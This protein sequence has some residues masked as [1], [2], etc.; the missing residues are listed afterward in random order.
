MFTGRTDEVCCVS[1]LLVAQLKGVVVEGSGWEGVRASKINAVVQLEG[2]TMRNNSD[3]DC[4]AVD[5][6]RIERR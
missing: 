3:G 6:G 5:G 4:Q 2:C 1:C